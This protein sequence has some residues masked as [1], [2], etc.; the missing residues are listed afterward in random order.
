[1]KA[2]VARN[3]ELDSYVDVALKIIYLIRYLL[4][5]KF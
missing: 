4:I 5:V 3:F 2:L 1:M